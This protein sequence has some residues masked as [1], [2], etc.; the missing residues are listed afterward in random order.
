MESGEGIGID[1]SGYFKGYIVRL[2]TAYEEV[3]AF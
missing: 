2:L 1:D 3:Y